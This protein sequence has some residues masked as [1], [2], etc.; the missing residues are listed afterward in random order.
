MAAP[1]GND[2]APSRAGAGSTAQARLFQIRLLVVLLTLLGLWIG[3]SFLLPL[4]WAAVLAIA[5]WPLY[6]R[7]AR[8]R[9][10]GKPLLLAPFGFTLATALV[11]MLPLAIVAVEA[12]RD[13]QAAVGWLT[14]AQKSGVAAPLWLGDLPFVG[15]RAL[16]WWQANLADPRG[17]ARL[18][19]QVDAA[20]AVRWMGAIAAEVASRSLFFAVTL[21]AF[22]FILRDGDRIGRTVNRL[23]RRLYGGF[24]E[25][26]TARLG[27][28]VRGAVNGT[29]L[30][31]I[32][33]GALIGVGYAVAGVPR[34]VLFTL[35]TVAVAMLPLGAWLAFGLASLVLLASGE[36]AAGLALF[37]FG[38]AVMLI[39]DNIVQPALIGNSVRLPFLWTLVGTFGGLESFGLVG[40]FV[41]PAVMAALFLV[42]K[43]WLGADAAAALEG[44]KR[45]R[46]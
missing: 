3:R 4:A 14:Q 44:R 42:W 1:S 16:S 40:L 30:V 13:S 45:A 29:V 34:P 46:P 27:E 20:A 6:A 7:M 2:K 38:A 21:L 23:A 15:A 32:G 17:A 33:E 12:A 18:L 31:A 19:G 10:P 26:F 9:P 36:F 24:G 8:S 35:A 28:A 41:G 22:F 37:G 11:L 5:L 39:G 25:R 43:E